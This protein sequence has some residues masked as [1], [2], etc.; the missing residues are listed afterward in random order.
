MAQSL[1]IFKEPY[2]SLPLPIIGSVPHE[3]PGAS[4][5]YSFDDLISVVTPAC[6]WTILTFVILTLPCNRLFYIRIPSDLSP[7]GYHKRLIVPGNLGSLGP[8]VNSIFGGGNGSLLYLHKTIRSVNLATKVIWV[9]PCNTGQS[10]SDL[11][12]RI[13]LTKPK[14]EYKYFQDGDIIIGGVQS[15]HTGVYYIPDINGKHIPLCISPSYNYYQDIISLLFAIDDINKNPDLLPNITVGYQVYDSCMEPSLAIR[16]ILQILSGPGEMVPNY[17]CGDYGKVIGFIADRSIV[18]TLPIAQFLTSYGYTQISYG[19]TD[20]VLNDR[21]LYPYHFS[22]GLN[23]D[24]QHIAI[25]ELVE[26]LGWTWVIILAPG[27]DHE[28]RESESKNLRNEINK[29]GACVDFIGTLTGDR[30]ANIR[31]LE[32]IQKSTAEVVVLCGRLFPTEFLISLVETMIKDKTCVTLD[33]EKDDLF[34]KAYGTVFN[35]CSSLEISVWP[36]T[37]NYQV[38]R[39]ATG[40][41][42]AEH[43]M[44]SSS[45][46]SH[47]KDIHK[48]IHRKQ[49]HRYLR[50]VRFT[51]PCGTEIN[52][53]ELNKSPVK[54]GIS[55]WPIYFNSENKQ[56]PVGEYF[57]SDSGSSLKIDIQSI[58]WKKNTNNQILKSQCSPNCPPG[59][60]KV[61][62]ERAPPCCYDCAR[63][64]EGEISNLTDMEN[65]LKC[66][67]YEWPNNEKT[68]CIEKQTE[69]LSYEGDSLTLVFIVLSVVSLLLVI[70]LIG[71]FI[72]YRDTPLVKANNRNLSFILLFSIKL[73]F[74]SVFLFLGRPSDITCMLRQTSFGISFSIAISSV[75]AKT[76]MVCIAF[77]ASKPDSPW[78]KCLKVQ[79]AHCIGVI[80]SLIQFLISAIWLAL[81]PPFV[82]LNLLSEPGKIIIQCNEGSVIAFYIVLS[83]MGLLASVSF[84]VAFLARTLPDSFNEAK[85]ITFSMLLFCS[86]WI[87]MIPAYLSTKGKYMVAVEIFAI[88]S[89][90]CGLLFCI[91]LPKCYIIIF[92]PKRNTKQY[93]LGNNK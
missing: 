56:I 51:E 11:Q 86:V 71:I 53:N 54:Y 93:V 14:Y 26:R 22:T 29:H 76:I 43:L 17:S 84:I 87:T 45:G 34:Q 27:D 73:S 9:I 28:E 59:Y 32:R 67:I 52:F 4:V 61:T 92:K 31:T 80:C 75:L 13:H 74:L 35:N 24:I 1:K 36:L 7:E 21:T 3:F 60:R 8:E 37:P 77:K 47:H 15:V 49:L 90:S 16:N 88:I 2:Y 83:Y 62:R 23:D 40:L 12:C 50:N 81:Y 91:F 38:Y 41:A 68:M 18:T 39:A 63:C 58:F 46:K 70:V 20:P 19:A 25:A 89:S 72:S 6:F 78:R 85:Y 57:W 5:L 10:G 82:E 79:L 64:S 69:F 55:T 66:P 44:L 33:K 65:C 42:H 30:I 48:Y